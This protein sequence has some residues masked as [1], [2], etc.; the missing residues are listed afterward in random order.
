MGASLNLERITKVKDSGKSPDPITEGA[1]KKKA[2]KVRSANEVL[3]DAAGK[4]T[5]RRT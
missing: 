1:V 4:T 2:F 5:W 3:E